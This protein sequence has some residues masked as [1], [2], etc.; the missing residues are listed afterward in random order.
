MSLD[1]GA[2]T[3][4]FKRADR[5]PAPPSPDPP[6]TGQ[7]PTVYSN[8]PAEAEKVGSANL[9]PRRASGRGPRRRRWTM[10]GSPAERR[11]EALDPPAPELHPCPFCGKRHQPAPVVNGGGLA[12][13]SRPILADPYSTRPEPL[14]R[15]VGDTSSLR[16]DAFNPWRAGPA[17]EPPPPAAALT[18]R[19]R[20]ARLW[21]GDEPP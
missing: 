8:T 18:L 11:Q 2:L 10:P 15:E 6:V 19:E 20:M 16:R 3:E 13:Y 5:P 7:G 21:R 1:L 4:R 12:A 9:P 17:E 14:G